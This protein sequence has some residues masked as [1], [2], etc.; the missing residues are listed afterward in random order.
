MIV[1]TIRKF[2]YN[3]FICQSIVDYTEFHLTRSF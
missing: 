3:G 2:D 1:K